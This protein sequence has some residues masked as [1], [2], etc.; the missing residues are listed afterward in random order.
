MLRHIK[1]KR[2][3][4]NYPVRK[5]RKRKDNG[6]SAKESVFKRILN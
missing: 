3:E 5:S 6:G 1:V 4:R 2:G